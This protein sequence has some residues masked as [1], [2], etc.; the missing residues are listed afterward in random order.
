MVSPGLCFLLGFGCSPRPGRQADRRDVATEHVEGLN[1]GVDR[2]KGGS[3]GGGGQA[4][5]DSERVLLADLARLVR[6]TPGVVEGCGNLGER[7]ESAFW[8]GGFVAGVLAV[9]A[10]QAGIVFLVLALRRTN[11]N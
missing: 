11:S 6:L 9:L 10:V 4:D 1:F 7:C 2:G 3:G 8:T 5:R